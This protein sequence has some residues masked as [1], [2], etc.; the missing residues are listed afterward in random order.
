[1]VS[2]AFRSSGGCFSDKPATRQLR[3]CD[4]VHVS[5]RI[6]YQAQA[7]DLT[8]STHFARSG[9]L[10][11]AVWRT[12][13]F[14]TLV[15]I[16]A[17]DEPPPGSAKLCY[18]M[19]H[20]HSHCHFS[21]VPI[22][23]CGQHLSSLHTRCPALGNPVA[24]HWATPVPALDT[25]ACTGE[26]TLDTLALHWLTPQPARLTP[27]LP[28]PCNSCTDSLHWLTTACTGTC[29]DT[30]GPAPGNPA[31]CI[32]LPAPRTTPRPAAPALNTPAPHWATPAPHWANHS[33]ALDTQGRGLTVRGRP[34]AV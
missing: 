10:L 4:F 17:A 1:M 8:S 6:S 2:H 31:A 27:R 18:P 15:G 19:P 30:L 12:L 25:L 13:L 34:G 5:K 3:L 22:A 26:T 23:H 11:V 20:R 9:P 28:V 29:I 24:P 16:W 21:M 33:P 7:K 32:G 14:G